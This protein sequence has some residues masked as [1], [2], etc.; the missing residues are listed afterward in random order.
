MQNLKSPDCNS[1]NTVLGQH[2]KVR[3]RLNPRK[4]GCTLARFAG[5]SYVDAPCDRDAL[6][7]LKANSGQEWRLWPRRGLAG[8]P[9]RLTTEVSG[10]SS[11]LRSAG[12]VQQRMP[13]TGS[14]PH[15]FIQAD[16]AVLPINSDMK[17]NAC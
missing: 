11:A 1:R 10:P 7:C 12:A 16:S 5:P 17:S 6:A 14:C 8:T 13:P 4:L 3:S 2:S 15:Q 9:A